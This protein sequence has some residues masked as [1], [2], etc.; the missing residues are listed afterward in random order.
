MTRDIAMLVQ[1][2]I[3]SGQ[4]E[5]IIKKRG[6]KLIEDVKL[7]DV[8]KGSQVADGLKSMAYSIAFRA[9]DRTLTDEEIG[10]KMDTI[11]RSLEK[12]VSATLRDK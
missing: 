7:F 5:H 3:L 2:D 8:Y 11:I 12:E 10:E 6:G 9:P 4:I 1:D